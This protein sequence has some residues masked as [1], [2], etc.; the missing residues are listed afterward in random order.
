MIS[1]F[2]TDFTAGIKS[3]LCV[4]VLATFSYFNFNCRHSKVIEE[5]DCAVSLRPA[6][7]TKRNSA[8]FSDTSE[9]PYVDLDASFDSQ[10]KKGSGLQRAES[11]SKLHNAARKL[12]RSLSGKNLSNKYKNSTEKRVEPEPPAEPVVRPPSRS[13]SL[14]KVC[15][16]I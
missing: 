13:N 4:L 3:S 11:T 14:V 15:F 2:H 6:A 9:S 5:E 10:T 16:I 1:K 8:V 12:R 7:N